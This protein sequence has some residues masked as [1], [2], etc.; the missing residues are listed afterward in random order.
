MTLVVVGKGASSL[1]SCSEN[2]TLVCICAC[3][4]GLE[5]AFG[6]ISNGP[7]VG[8][9]NGLG[10]IACPSIINAHLSMVL[11][12]V[13]D[14]GGNPWVSAQACSGPL[15]WVP[16]GSMMGEQSTLVPHHAI[17]N[18][19]SPRLTWAACQLHHA[20]DSMS[21]LWAGIKS[22]CIFNSQNMLS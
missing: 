9:L 18:C 8:T 4:D 10:V 21:Y 6:Y 17:P 2:V 7:P 5:R 13:S 1:T 19:P 12:D 14:P 11:P 20:S 22:P 3:C 15:P 16:V